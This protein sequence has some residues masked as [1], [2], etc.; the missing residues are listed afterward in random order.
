METEQLARLR[1]T[2]KTFKFVLPPWRSA[3]D[4]LKRRIQNKEVDPWQ[5]VRISSPNDDDNSL[6]MAAPDQFTVTV[7][8]IYERGVFRLNMR[9]PI[10]NR[11]SS[12]FILMAA[13]ITPISCDGPWFAHL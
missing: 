11:Y 1:E 4:A 6:D 10:Y 9:L 3:A 2:C 12:A 5:D 8:E 13:R 7:L